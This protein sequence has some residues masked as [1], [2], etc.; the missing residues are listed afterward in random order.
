MLINKAEKY[1][2]NDNND[3]KNSAA[4]DDS[5][6]LS[7][8]SHQQLKQY[9]NE[10]GHDWK[11]VESEIKDVLIKTIISAEP[12]I[13]HQLNVATRYKNWCFELYGFDILLDHKLKPW[14]IEV[15]TNP[16]LSSSSAFDKNIKTRLICDTLTLVGLKAY[17]KQKFKQEQEKLASIRRI[18]G[19]SKMNKASLAELRDSKIQTQFG[20]F[21]GDNEV[22]DQFIEQETRLG[23]FERIFPHDY[24]VN[25]YSQFF[26]TDRANNEFIKNY[27]CSC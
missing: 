4:W 13:V 17:D 26:E 18:N 3:P 7:K 19:L 24:N 12:H 14:L 22:L 2:K 25:Y 15:N 16:S 5:H 23:G 11:S 27:I 21:M 6:I 8:W 1:I 9:I 20:G 10:L